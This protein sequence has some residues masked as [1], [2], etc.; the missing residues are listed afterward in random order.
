MRQP[1]AA[2]ACFST[3]SGVRPMASMMPLRMSMVIALFTL[4]P[5]KSIPARFRT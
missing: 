2:E 3:I 4:M 5:V 1:V